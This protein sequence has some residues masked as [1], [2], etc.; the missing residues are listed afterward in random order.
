MKLQFTHRSLSTATGA[1]FAVRPEWSQKAAHN[2]PAYET[3]F[4]SCLDTGSD[5]ET[6]SYQG[7]RVSLVIAEGHMRRP[8]LPWRSN[9]NF[10]ARG[11]AA[12]YTT[13]PPPTQFP[14]STLIPSPTTKSKARV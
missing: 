8:M 5:S 9:T 12:K 6:R 3:S 10:G 4:Q 11:I 2:P 14:P 1:G 13:L 7:S